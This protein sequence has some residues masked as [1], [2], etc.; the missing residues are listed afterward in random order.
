MPTTTDSVPQ[1]FAL[2]LVASVRP[3][4]KPVGWGDEPFTEERPTNRPITAVAETEFSLPYGSF[5]IGGWYWSPSDIV[6]R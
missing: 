4:A 2:G 6:V 3:R 1:H 5:E